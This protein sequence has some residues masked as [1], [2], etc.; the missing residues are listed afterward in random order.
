[1]VTEGKYLNEPWWVLE[2]QRYEF[3]VFVECW[4]WIWA[5]SESIGNGN[6]KIHINSKIFDNFFNVEVMFCFGTPLLKMI[7]NESQLFGF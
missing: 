5:V 3:G 2:E 4:A 1:M 6:I 7:L